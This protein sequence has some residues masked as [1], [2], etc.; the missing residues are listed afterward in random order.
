MDLITTDIL[1]QLCPNLHPERCKIIVNHHNNICPEYGINNADILHEFLANEIIESMEFTRYE[2]NLNYSSEAL[3]ATFSRERIST[4]DA[5]RYGRTKS[6]PANQR[7]IAN[8][9]YGGAWGMKNLGNI[10]PEDGFIFRG[11]GAMQLT[12]RNNLTW[13]ANY[14]KE[15][16]GINKPAETWA[17]WLR[18][19]DEYSIHS[20]CWVFSVCKHLND[21]ALDDKMKEIV[22]RINGGYNGLAERMKVYEQCK[23]LIV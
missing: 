9:V 22:K 15:T 4:E 19:N 5:I 18:T 14:M 7:M 6:H 23:K 3:V 12:G 21:E 11:S 20:A 8:C 10:A 1:K 13:F 17:S 2:E 16:H